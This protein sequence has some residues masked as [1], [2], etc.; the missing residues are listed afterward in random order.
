VRFV[1]AKSIECQDLQAL[2][3]IRDRLVHSTRGLDH[4]TGGPVKA[5]SDYLWLW[6][7][8]F[9]WLSIW[10]SRRGWSGGWR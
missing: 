1:P 7:D 9:L 2:H 10:L 4:L 6:G 8:R 5:E 3:R